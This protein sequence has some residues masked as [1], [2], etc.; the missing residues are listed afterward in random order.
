MQ[1]IITIDVVA[2]TISI[3]AAESE[4]NSIAIKLI[5]CTGNETS[6][7]VEFYKAENYLGSTALDK[8][9]QEY[10]VAV[11]DECINDGHIFHFRYVHS[12][13]ST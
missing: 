8:G 10:L 9:K 12:E 13:K 4:E 11:P 5:N 2:D 3:N 7:C 6:P 1:N